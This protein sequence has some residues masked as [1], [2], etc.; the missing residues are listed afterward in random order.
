MVSGLSYNTPQ[1]ASD[2]QIMTYRETCILLPC[3]SLE[4]FPMHYEGED[5][6]GLMAAWTSLWHPALLATTGSAPSWHRGDSPPGDL[7]DM[8]ILAPGVS[9]SELPTGFADRALEE[10]ACLIEG[11]NLSEGRGTTRP[12]EIVGAPWIDPDALVSCLAEQELPASIIV[13]CSHGN[14]QK[15]PA[16]Q[17]Q[18]V[19]DLCDQI[20]QGQTAIRG[21][22]LESHLEG[23]NQPVVQGQELTYGQSITD[24]CLSLADT[25]PLLE[26]LAAAIRK[27]N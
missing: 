26:Y 25:G 16:R 15:D 1:F 5:A 4:D 24:A 2:K 18:V 10:G 6:D 11:T 13:D 22:M 8:L 19:A 27:V 17:A 20:E 21:I 12:F 14:S 23:G 7:S 9:E 3:H